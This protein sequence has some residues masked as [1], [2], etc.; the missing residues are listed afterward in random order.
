MPGS[1]YYFRGT[2]LLKTK[3]EFTKL[4]NMG[5]GRFMVYTIKHNT[6]LSL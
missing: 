4:K 6:R 1:V 3:N 2:I 5:Q